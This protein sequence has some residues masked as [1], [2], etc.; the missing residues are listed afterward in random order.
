MKKIINTIFIAFLV[1]TTVCVLGCSTG[2]DGGSQEEPYPTPDISGVWLG[3]FDSQSQGLVFSIGIIIEDEG[4]YEAR[5]ISEG[6]Q[7]ISPISPNGLSQDFVSSALVVT[8]NSVIFSGDIDQYIWSSTED[9]YSTVR[10]VLYM[11]GA[12]AEKN[13]L[14]LGFPGGAFKYYEKEGDIISETQ[15]KETGV[16]AF[17]YNTT[18]DVSPNVQTLGGQWTINNAWQHG[19][20]ITLTITPDPLISNTSGGIVSGA[21]EI[22]NDFTG[23]IVIHYSPIP[24]NV[25]D[26][27]LRMNDSIN[28][29]GLATL[30]LEMSTTGIE[31]KNKTLAIGATSSDREYSVG[32]LAIFEK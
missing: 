17:V 19:N 8:P 9:D 28:L 1:I 25:Y 2:S 7:Y 24:H 20:T 30:V 22:G 26:V 13:S 3:Y 31:I 14:G 5:F 15:S 23:S 16:F 11:V 12:A 27:N 21:D 18:F 6:R 32:G 10:E 4:E 29:Q